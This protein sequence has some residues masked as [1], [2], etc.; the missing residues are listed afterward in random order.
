[1]ISESR[2]GKLFGFGRYICLYLATSDEGPLEDLV[3]AIAAGCNE[4]RQQ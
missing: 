4:G 2:L 3:Y 1:M